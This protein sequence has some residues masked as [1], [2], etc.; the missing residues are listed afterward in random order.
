MLLFHCQ[1]VASHTFAEADSST[2][3]G[4]SVGAVAEHP[5]E[6]EGEPAQEAH[7]LEQATESN[8]NEVSVNEQEVL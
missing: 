4:R 3:Q 6:K 1:P 7:V 2:D 5:E 8:E